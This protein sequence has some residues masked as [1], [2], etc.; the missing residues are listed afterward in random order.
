MDLHNCIGNLPKGAY[1]EC[2]IYC[3][4]TDKLE[5]WVSNS[6]YS[7]QVAYCP[8]CGYKAKVAPKIENY[9]KEII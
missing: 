5:L 1:G 3:A 7:S 9:N 4:E 8:Y 2:I 6:E